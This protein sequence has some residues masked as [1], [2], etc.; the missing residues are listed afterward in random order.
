MKPD[1]EKWGD[2]KVVTGF[3]IPSPEFSNAMAQANKAVKSVRKKLTKEKLRALL[4]PSERR[5]NE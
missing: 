5:R 4:K 1:K 2:S 3:V